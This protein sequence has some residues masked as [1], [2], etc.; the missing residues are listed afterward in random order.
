MAHCFG[1]PCGG[2]D[3][4]EKVVER[5]NND[6]EVRTLWRASNVTAIDRM[7]YSDHG[8]TH[9]KIVSK[10]ALKMLQI[11][12]E[13]GMKP[14]IVKNYN[15]G[16]SDAEVVVVLAASL[17]DIGH[18][19]HRTNHEEMSVMLAAPIIRRV[20][21]G[22]YD[23]AEKT[24]M[25]VETLHAMISHHEDI[26]PL[27]LEAGVVRVA[28]ALDMEKGRARVPFRAGSINIHSVSALAIERVR[29]IKGKDIPIHVDIMMNNSAGIF[30][31]DELLKDKIEKS[32]IRDK[33]EISVH[34]PKEEKR[35]VEPDR[36][37]SRTTMSPRALPSST[38]ALPYSFL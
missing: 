11:L 26:L 28:D 34:V 13:S 21:D 9:I 36:S 14:D 4:L 12:V 37:A 35:I 25:M 5:I 23:E 7:G 20:L 1:I 27:T 30:Q 2:N 19:I 38:K 33:I 3:V 15:L 17:H 18:G 16:V 22:L 29:V 10:L 24:I 31:I 6:V 32:G 8:P